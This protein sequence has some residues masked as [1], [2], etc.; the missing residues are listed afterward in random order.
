MTP[1]YLFV[2]DCNVINAWP[3]LRELGNLEQHYLH[4]LPGCA[5]I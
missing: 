5:I 4:N 2:D 3:E 1:G